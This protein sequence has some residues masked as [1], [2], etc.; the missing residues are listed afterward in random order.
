VEI[1]ADTRLS[2]VGKNEA[3]AALREETEA[4]LAALQ[5]AQQEAD[6]KRRTEL[7]SKLLDRSTL[8]NDPATTIAWRD[9]AQRAAVIEDTGDVKGAVSLVKQA[10]RNRDESLERS[11]LR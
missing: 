4:G 10:I 2:V 8:D 7:S 9:A 3:I 11:L 1:N 6:G 5:T